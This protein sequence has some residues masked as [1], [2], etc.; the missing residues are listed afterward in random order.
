MQTCKA[1]L[2]SSRVLM[3]SD[4]GVLGVTLSSGQQVCQVVICECCH[5]VQDACSSILLFL[6]SIPW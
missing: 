4:V 6:L 5:T 3:L 2:Q 1:H